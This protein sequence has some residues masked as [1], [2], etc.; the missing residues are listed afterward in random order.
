MFQELKFQLSSAILTVLTIAAVAA[1]IVSYDQNRKFPLPDDGVT[2]FDR[3]SS[4]GTVV[5]VHR[6]TPDSAGARADIHDGDE[7]LAINGSHLRNS[8]DVERILAYIGAWGQ[9]TYTIRRDGVEFT[10]KIYVGQSPRSNA[11][12]VLDAVGFAYLVIGLFIY[13]RRNSAYK[14]RHFYIFCLTSFIFFSFHYTGKLNTFDTVVYYGNQIAGWLA[15]TLFLHFCLTFPEPKKWWRERIH[16]PLLYI[17]GL[18]YTLVLVAVALGMLRFTS[19]QFIEVRPSRSASRK[20]SSFATSSSGCATA[21]S[22][23]LSRSRSSIPFRISSRA[24]GS[25]TPS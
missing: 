19:M 1:A 6:V 11:L 3:A 16:A 9:A 13:F 5:E 17:P 18:A 24:T 12:L 10:K 8:L 23:P 7:V 15:P 2:Y 20:T 22:L 4:S 21:R 14:A 25:N